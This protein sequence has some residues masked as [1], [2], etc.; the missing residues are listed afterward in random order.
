MSL[1]RTIN[2]KHNR[3]GSYLVEATLV[4]P[5]FFIAVFL[6]ISVI[7][8]ISACENIT[9]CTTEELR[10]EC[11]KSAFRKNS[12]VLPLKVTGRI[13]RENDIVN[14]SIVTEYDYLYS[15]NG[16]TDLVSIRN[17]NVFKSDDP[18]GMGGRL[19]FTNRIT[20]RAFSGTYYRGY[21]GTDDDRWVYIFPE[22]GEAFHNQ[23]CTYIKRSGKLEYLTGEIKKDY[24]PCKLCNASSAQTGSPVFCFTRYGEVYHLSDCSVVDRYYIE[25]RRGEAESKG[26]RPCSKCGG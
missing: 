17:R 14:S 1:I 3:K 16:I 11:M 15:K 5:V 21:D 10:F 19:C 8:V 25:V 7:P 23:S 4:I 6:L 9:Y 24:K 18:L 26:Y 13:L 22:W 2:E 20:A 12:T